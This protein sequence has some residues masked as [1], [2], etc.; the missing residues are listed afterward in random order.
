MKLTFILLTAAFLHVD[1]KTVAQTVTFS[2]KNEK[3]ENVFAEIK[4]QT[5]FVFFY[6]SQDINISRPVTITL[7]NVP[8]EDAL[9]RVMVDQP[10]TYI[11]KSNTVF[12]KA[13]QFSSS[14]LHQ[15]IDPLPPPIEV[16]GRVVNDKGEPVVRATI[17][18]KGKKNS[19][20][21]NENGE[22]V[23]SN[24][25]PKATLTISHVNIEPYEVRVEGRNIL[26]VS[27]KTRVVSLDD[28]VIKANTG[29][30]QVPLER[31]TGAFTHIT[32]AELDKSNSFNLKDR[33]ESLVPGMYFEPQ[34][35]EDQ[36]PTEE[37]SRSIVIRGVGTF[38]NNNP[39]IVIDGSPFY[40]DIIDPWSIIN[41]NDVE[42]ITV[43]KDAAAASIWGSQAANGVIVIT[44]K[45]GS[46][47]PGQPMLNVSMD[48]LV[49]PVP[50][51]FKVPWASSRESVDMYK[52]MILDKPWFDQLLDPVFADRYELP[53]VMDVLI[54][55]KRGTLSQAE[56]NQRLSELSAIDVRHE[57]R[58]LFFRKMESNK[59]LNLTFQS[60]TQ[61]N[62]VR[63]SFTGIFNNQY[64]KGN[65]DFQ[66][67]ANILDEYSP[68]TWLKF[69]FGSNI[70]MSNQ[71][72]NGASVND[73]SFI[74]QMSR[75]LDDNGN[76]LPMIQNSSE[77]TYYDIPTWRRRDTAA[78]YGL[79]YNWDWNLK[80]DI[81]NRDKRTQITNIR[82]LSNVRI[83]PFT[84]FDID[85]YYQYQKDHVLFKEIYN[86]NTWY[87]R[88]MVNNNARPNGTYPIPPGGMLYERQ[89]NGYSHNGRF[90][91]GYTKSFGDHAI[92]AIAGTEL[93]QNYYDQHGYGYYG[94]DAQALTNITSLD[95]LNT[96]T[97][98]MNGDVAGFGNMTIPAAPTQRFGIILGGNDDRF[99]STYANAGYTFR[100]KYDLTGSIRRDKTNLYGQAS[101]LSNL[102]QWSVGA[103]WKISDEN[104]FAIDFINT[105]KMR[106]SYG[107]NGNIDKS[108]S[109]YIIGTPWIDPI[110]GLPYAAVQQA[111][112]PGLTWERTGTYNLGLDFAILNNRLYGNLEIYSKRATNVLVQTEVNGT[113]GFQNNRA[114]V[115]TGNINNTGVEFLLNGRIIDNGEFRWHSRFNYGTNRNRASN[116][117]QVNR[118]IGAYTNLAFYYHLP[119]QPVDY[120]AAFEWAGYDSLGYDKFMY[121]GK[122]LSI[123]DVA[124]YNLLDPNDMFTIVGQRSPKH[125]GQWAN[126]FSYKGFDL[127]LSIQY[128]FG[129]VFVADYPA[130]S[131]SNTYFTSTRL[132]TFLPELM[133]DRWQSPADGNDASMYS[134]ENKLTGTQV[135]LLDYVARYSTR[136]VLNAG[137][138]RMQSIGLSYSIPSKIT[139]PLR[140]ARI[141]LEARNLG[142]LFVMNDRGIDPD[143]PPY[144]SSV[145]GALQYVV[146][147]RPQYSASLRFGL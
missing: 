115:N 125:F 83:T 111:P 16:R 2:A 27:V 48:Y 78:K 82:L 20:L 24:V 137:S 113:Y 42:S 21:T 124:N 71:E 69:S 126:T 5:G 118:S 41:P 131:M 70:F 61:L 79:P 103:G 68:K 52:W 107:F 130:S 135:T 89:T 66:V 10:L 3:L 28:V 127:H 6:S 112:N 108:A 143:F 138:I 81:D 15:T 121:Q 37:R 146:R 53:E 40:T 45:K 11:I 116:F 120:V 31:V 91:L 87:V 123:R 38:S 59:K 122:A 47:R 56:G 132:F 33:L 106:V 147:N 39:L 23:L 74:P 90:Q 77:D 51:L 85:L 25:D 29:Y 54:R 43:L 142:P 35:D 100:N 75:I 145:Y 7:N 13:K 134:L 102:P 76:Y 94:Y 140:N 8:V 19:V 64:S 86:E 44:T 141:Q 84:G 119:D 80:Q 88:N 101:T 136:N 32:A 60:G 4:K 96:I 26:L 105:L 95:F 34:F 98:K 99:V 110:T 57:F 144:S 114:T 14:S 139:G 50:D 72:R 97:P 22:F 117:K 49:Q 67:Q 1:A 109:P 55:M 92:R 104:F 133:V 62:N 30:Y 73:I 36:S 65:S 58:D 17:T 46:T 93:R 128:K 18:E 63:T 9:K 129:H 12:V